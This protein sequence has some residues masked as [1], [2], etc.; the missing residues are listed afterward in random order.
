MYTDMEN[1]PCI[2]ARPEAYLAVSPTTRPSCAEASAELLRRAQP[3]M[4]SAALR[5]PSEYLNLKLLHSYAFKMCVS[6][7]GNLYSGI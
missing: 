1:P 2:A 4:I 3:S 7:K 6:G 5:V